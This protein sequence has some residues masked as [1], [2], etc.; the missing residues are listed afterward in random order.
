MIRKRNCVFWVC[1]MTRFGK[2]MRAF[3]IL[4]ELAP[5][6]RAHV[7]SEARA[8]DDRLEAAGNDVVLDTNAM[9]HVL[10]GKQSMPELLEHLGEPRKKIRFLA[11]RT[12]LTVFR[13]IKIEVIEQRFH[14]RELVV[15]PLF[16]HE[17]VAARPEFFRID[18]EHRKEHL[19][20]HVIGRERL[21]VVVNDRNDVLRR[22][23]AKSLWVERREVDARRPQ[24]KAGR[25]CGGQNV[26][27]STSNV[28]SSTFN[29]QRPNR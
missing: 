4:R 15:E 1:E 28:Q 25:A 12:Q 16:A 26:Q 23:H 10:R 14:V 11:E 9:R 8:I 3:A 27:R 6:D 19:V 5:K 29:V 24:P 17:I 18:P 2:V 13:T 20:L 22:R 7:R 21:I